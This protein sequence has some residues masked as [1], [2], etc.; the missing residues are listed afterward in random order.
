MAAAVDSTLADVLERRYLG[1]IELGRGVAEAADW[2]QLAAAVSRGLDAARPEPAADPPGVR[3]LA[4]TADGLDELGAHPEGHAFPHT[5]RRDLRR[6][7]ELAEPAAGPERG[8]LVGLHAGGVALGVLEVDDAAA[9]GELI[10][11]AAPLVAWR[12]SMLAGQ[13]VGD[14]LLSP[15]SVGGS[16]DAAELMA[17]FASEAR[18]ELDH[19]RLS[20]YLLA[21]EGRAFERF[22]VATSPIIPGEGVVIP[23]EDVGLRH[24]VIAN[25]AL[26]SSD[27]ANDPRIV[28]REDRVIARA[29]FHGLLSVPLRLHGRPIG[30]LNF[31]S[32]TPGFYRDADIPI[33]QQ[34]ADQI[35]GFVGNLQVQ[36]RMRTLI[37]HEA[38]E[39]ER[40]RVG[41]DIYHAVAQAVPEIER[42]GAELRQRVAQVDPGAAEQ[43]RRVQELARQA[44]AD[45]RRAVADIIPRGLDAKSL[46]EAVRSTA[47]A[48]DDTGLACHLDIAGDTTLLTG[49]VRR[50]AF[51]IVQE[52]LENVRQHARARTV[53]VTVRCGRDLILTVEDDGTGF[54]L[55]EAEHGVGLGLRFMCDRAQALGGVL[56]VRSAPGSG[57]VVRFEVLGATTPG[58]HAPAGEDYE[59]RGA[60]TA[61]ALRVFVADRHPLMRAGLSRL[62]ASAHDL[63][64]VGE[65]ATAEEARGLV[66]RLRPDVVLLDA[67]LAQADG[68]ALVRDIRAQAAGVAV[69]VM[70]ESSTGRESALADAGASGF[71][72]KLIDEAELAEAVRAVASGTAV[73]LPEPPASGP[74]T[75][76]TPRERTVLALMAAG[77]TNSE[78]GR[79]LFLATKTVERQLATIVRKLGARNRAHATALAVARHMVDPPDA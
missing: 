11:H 77:H 8:M 17:T 27:L 41:R 4:L 56:S 43:A 32:R 35:A 52:A 75:A 61:T 28:G 64:V 59:A 30:V 53:R 68:D 33:A 3:V 54:Q 62:V 16:S 40:T 63:R 65:A 12:A 51:R 1:L 74:P 46:E 21:C 67:A 34:I 23:F 71:L 38:A 44:M 13:G 50:G 10:A 7:M 6:A 45:V 42:A 2:G 26:V 31:V 72:L 15:L 76:L 25:R 9:D 24:V 36:E 22:A 66:R 79:Q 73:A 69:V 60:S 14:V 78:I 37:R 19:D 29:G 55:H 39:Q 48:I 49:A 20:A 47:E 70:S 58:E 57:T 18:R 5:P